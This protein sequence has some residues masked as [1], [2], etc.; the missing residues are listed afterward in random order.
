MVAAAAEQAIQLMAAAAAEQVIGL[1]AA[2]MVAKTDESDQRW[3]WNRINSFRPCLG[4]SESTV[5]GH[6][7]GQQRQRHRSNS[8]SNPEIISPAVFGLAQGHP[9]STVLGHAQGHPKQTNPI[10]ISSSF[11]PCLGPSKISC[12]SMAA[13]AKKTNPINGDGDKTSQSHLWRRRQRQQQN[14]SI[15]SMATAAAT[16]AAMVAAAATAERGS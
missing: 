8:D 10:N 16:V 6:A 4:P 1:I 2:A 15:R 9:E 12:R 3:W 5:L 11:R 13:A 7:Q 14:S